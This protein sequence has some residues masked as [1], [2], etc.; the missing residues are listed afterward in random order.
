MHRKL[1]CV[2]THKV[3][4]QTPSKLNCSPRREWCTLIAPK[5]AIWGTNMKWRISMIRDMPIKNLVLVNEFIWDFNL[6]D[7]SPFQKEILILS[8]R[9]YDPYQIMERVRKVAY[10][11]NFLN[12]A[13]PSSFSRVSIKEATGSKE[14]NKHPTSGHGRKHLTGRIF[15]QVPNFTI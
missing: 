10:S 13:N 4:Q 15:P 3:D 12:A 5:E 6:T 14:P 1:R 7:K 8:P 11:W 2:S 9:I